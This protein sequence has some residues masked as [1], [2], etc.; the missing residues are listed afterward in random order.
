MQPQLKILTYNIHK[1]FSVGNR[2]FVLDAIREALRSSGAD[3]L[4]LQEAQGEHQIHVGRIPGWPLES[5]FEYLA[6][7]I[8]PHHAYGRNAVYDHGHHG[9]AILSRYPFADYENINVSS[10]RRASR[11]ILHGTI[12]LDETGQEVHVICIHFG[13]FASERHRQLRTLCQHIKLKISVDAPLIV[14][15]DFNDWRGHASQYLSGQAG[16]T[17]VF[18]HTHGRYARSWPAW[19]PLLTMDR[20]YYRGLQLDHCERLV[21]SPWQ[22]L[23]DHAPLMATFNLPDQAPT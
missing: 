22:K 14:A 3:L 18:K 1:G 21:H 15:G 19:M 12:R 20:I 7:K 9:N 16:L 4:F 8:W 2:R 17:E 5:Q 13:L 23:S 6:D 11:S 10:F